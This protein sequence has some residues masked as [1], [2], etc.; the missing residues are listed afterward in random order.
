MAGSWI[1][2]LAVLWAVC[3]SLGVRIIN[4]NNN[5]VEIFEDS[6]APVTCGDITSTADVVWLPGDGGNIGECKA[7]GSC[8][9][10][11]ALFTDFTLSRSPQ[12]TESQLT[13]VPDYR[14]HAGV[15]V[16]CLDRG[17]GS[18]ASC[19]LVI[20]RHSE[21]SECHV[22]TN[23]VDWTVS[24]SC[25]VQQAFS[26]DDIYS[27]SWKMN[28]GQQTFGGFDNNREMCSFTN[29]P[30]PPEKGVYTF[31]IVV[32]P[33]PTTAFSQTVTTGSVFTP[34][35]LSTTP[36]VTGADHSHEPPGSLVWI[37]VGVVTAVAV[38]VILITVIAI[39]IN[40][41]KCKFHA[42]TKGKPSNKEYDDF[43]EDINVVYHPADGQCP[44]VTDAEQHYYSTPFD[45]TSKMWSATTTPTDIIDKEG[46]R[47]VTA[48]YD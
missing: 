27:C 21:L 2:F 35:T 37:I 14:R 47:H 15:T 33:P 39:A 26:S 19:T 10:G 23:P 6:P 9:P 31:T 16:T 30:L 18:T 20:R 17:S 5:Q 11:T 13:L 36:N 22:T 28:D 29:K 42:V 1:T 8:S 34:V 24:G 25:R 32:F 7:D 4:C 40:R 44:Q 38:V 41:R 45:V 3:G 46:P 12:S 48:L 43:E